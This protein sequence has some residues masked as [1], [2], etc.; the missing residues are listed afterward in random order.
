ML[1]VTR[2]LF[3]SPFPLLCTCSFSDKVHS[4]NKHV[5]DDSHFG[6]RQQLPYL[7]FGE[8][9]LWQPASKQATNDDSFKQLSGIINSTVHI[10]KSVASLPAPGFLESQGFKKPV[11]LQIPCMPFEKTYHQWKMKRKG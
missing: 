5:L 1:P 2:A 10:K 8:Y 4:C 11:N 9:L 7:L 6:A 3:L